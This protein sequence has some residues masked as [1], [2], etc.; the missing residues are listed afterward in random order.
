MVFKFLD[1]AGGFLLFSLNRC[2]M[3]LGFFFSVVLAV[4]EYFC[5]RLFLL[6]K[7]ISK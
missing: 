7:K 6:I 1:I 2:K 4:S 5:G 3:I